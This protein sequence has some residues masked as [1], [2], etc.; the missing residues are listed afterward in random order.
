MKSK[1]GAAFVLGPVFITTTCCHLSRRIRQIVHENKN[2][3]L[4]ETPSGPEI[5]SLHNFL[6]PPICHDYFL[7]S[8]FSASGWEQ[9]SGF[10]DHGRTCSW[11]TSHFVSSSV[12]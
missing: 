11:R 5:N 2:L 8:V 10:F 7:C 1:G 6:N 3:C 9:S 4:A 12:Y